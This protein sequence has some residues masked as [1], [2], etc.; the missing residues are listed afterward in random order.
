MKKRIAGILII[1]LAV[2]LLSPAGQMDRVYATEQDQPK[3]M[4]KEL[5]NSQQETG[6]LK[7]SGKVNVKNVGI[8]RYAQSVTAYKESFGNQ[9]EGESKALYDRM[10][11]QYVT[12]QSTEDRNCTKCSRCLQL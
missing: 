9:L 5:K 8:S 12:G 10:V 4:N 1:A 2:M 11:Q 6:N 7:P 3:K